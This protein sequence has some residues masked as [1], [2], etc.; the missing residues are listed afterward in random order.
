SGVR[1]GPL[2][3]TGAP[4]STGKNVIT[5]LP[6][7]ISQPGSYVLNGNLTCS[8]CTGGQSGINVTAS[9]V[10]IDLQGFKLEGVS[11]A[12]YG[13]AANGTYNLVVRNGTLLTWPFGAIFDSTGG[14]VVVENIT[15]DKR[16]WLG[17]RSRVS[18]CRIDGS[19][20]EGI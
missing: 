8:A 15:A 9:F 20:A 11:G 12:G 2:D 3:P 4:G 16:L 5:S 18:D 13:I 1:G 10:T 17:F 19:N 6:V 7:T 14:G